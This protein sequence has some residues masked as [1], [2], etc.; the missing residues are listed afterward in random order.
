MAVAAGTKLGRYEIRWQLGAGGMVE[1]L[2]TEIKR[3]KRGVAI[4]MAAIVL[5]S[6]ASIAYYFYFARSGSRTAINSIA[7]LPFANTSNDQ[8]VEYLSAAI[9][10]AL[11]NSLT[12]LRSVKSHRTRDGFPFTGRELDPSA[13]GRVERTVLMGR[14]GQMGDTLNIQVDLVEA[15]TGVQLW[16]EEHKRRVSDVLTV[17]QTIAREVTE[18]LRLIVG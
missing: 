1:Y 17:K 16:G 4:A 18:K 6:V 5:F 2:I 15:T 11:I 8:N 14:V 10:E 12:E 9:S 13:V 3:H 7:V